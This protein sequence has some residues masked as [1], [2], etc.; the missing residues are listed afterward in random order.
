MVFGIKL[1]L[2]HQLSVIIKKASSC[3]FVQYPDNYW[4]NAQKI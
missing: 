3:V 4:D 2:Y 1:I